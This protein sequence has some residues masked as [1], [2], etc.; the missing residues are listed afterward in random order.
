[1]LSKLWNAFLD[2]LF[3]VL[4]WILPDAKKLDSSSWVIRMW[5]AAVFGACLPILVPCWLFKA[6]L[7]QTQVALQVEYGD[8]RRMS[9]EEQWELG[10]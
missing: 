4:G 2:I 10:E 5:A 6:Y 7:N 3:A 9:L 1:M 8:Q